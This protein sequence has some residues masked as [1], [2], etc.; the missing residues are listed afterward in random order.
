M[1]DRDEIIDIIEQE[2]GSIEDAFYEDTQDGICHNC[3]NIQSNVE[4]D[5]HEC[6]C[7]NCEQHTV[8]GIE[9]TVITLA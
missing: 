6:L 9:E 5:A 2:Y 4:P 3:G 8:Y 7:E 1:L